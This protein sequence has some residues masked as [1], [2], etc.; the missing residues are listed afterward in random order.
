[1]LLIYITLLAEKLKLTKLNFRLF[2]PR[3]L[4]VIEELFNPRSGLGGLRVYGLGG[5]GKSLI[6]KLSR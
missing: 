4:V 2:C 6:F 1:M 5:I 3:K